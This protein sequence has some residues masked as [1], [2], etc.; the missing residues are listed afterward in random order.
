MKVGESRNFSKKNN[1]ISNFKVS[2]N[3]NNYNL[4]QDTN[5]ECC[6]EHFGILYE[7]LH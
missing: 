3:Y 2:G 1:K 6:D 4:A 5:E 7:F